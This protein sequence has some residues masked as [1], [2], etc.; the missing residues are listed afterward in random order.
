[1]EIGTLWIFQANSEMNKITNMTPLTKVDGIP[2][3]RMLNPLFNTW[4]VS[5][6][7]LVT[8]RR[9]I[10]HDILM[11]SGNKRSAQC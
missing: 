5:R 9:D 2:A 6:R 11:I 7:R 3:A 10:K 8:I 4:D 1:M